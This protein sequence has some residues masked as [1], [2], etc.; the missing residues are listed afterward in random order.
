LDGSLVGL[1]ETF[2]RKLACGGEQGR[3]LLCQEVTMRPPEVFVRELSEREGVRLKTISKRAKYGPPPVSWSQLLSWSWLCA[4]EGRSYRCQERVVC[5]I[6]P[7]PQVTEM[8]GA[9]GPGVP[10]WASRSARRA[11]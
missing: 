10:G 3:V 8:I 4:T 11:W 2:D 1:P 5:P 6:G 9:R 7:A